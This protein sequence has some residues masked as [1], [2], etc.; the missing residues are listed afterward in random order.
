MTQEK[1]EAIRSSLMALSKYIKRGESE[2]LRGVSDPL[3][4][5]QE[6]CEL[7]G[8]ID[9]F[10]SVDKDFQMPGNLVEFA[11][12]N[13]IDIKPENLVVYAAKNRLLI[14]EKNPLVFA[15]DKGVRIEGKNPFVWASQKTYKGNKKLKIEN[16]DPILWA[17]EKGVD[18]D[19]ED[20]FIFAAKNKILFQAWDVKY[21]PIIYAYK[22][23]L[24]INAKEPFVA[25]AEAGLT[26]GNMDYIER[27]IEKGIDMDGKTPMRFA[28]SLFP[29]NEKVLEKYEL[30]YQIKYNLKD[31]KRYISEKELQG[32]YIKDP[33]A[34]AVDAKINIFGKDPIVWAIENKRKIDGKDPIVWALEN[35]KGINAKPPHPEYPSS[36]DPLIYAIAQKIKIENMDPFHWVVHKKKKITG[37]DPIVWA[38][39][40]KVYIEYQGD[41]IYPA[42][43]AALNNVKIEGKHPVEYALENKVT[44]GR[45]KKQEKWEEQYKEL[46][47]HPMVWALEHRR[48]NFYKNSR[49]RKYHQREYKKYHGKE[50]KGY[51]D[52]YTIEG[53]NPVIWAAKNKKNIWIWSGPKKDKKVDVDPIIWAHEY[54]RG[55]GYVEYAVKNGI[56]IAYEG[57][58]R[59]A[60]NYAIA[61]GV[62]IDSLDPVEY[63]V[64]NHM[65]LYDP[66][67]QKEV[68]AIDYAKARNIKVS[69]PDINTDSPPKKSAKRVLDEA[70]EIVNKMRFSRS[71]KPKKSQVKRRKG[72]A[73]LSI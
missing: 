48:G 56:D 36:V 67:E 65:T 10:S 62:K 61:K 53:D 32:T 28:E 60:I 68:S 73:T 4:R 69:V 45:Y 19:G 20:A 63:A 54:Y 38:L 41:L 6:Y 70:K 25:A 3:E 27:A 9:I 35:K 18:I 15:H 33:I 50:D 5:Y 29:G 8:G 43:W 47:E 58:K 44:I 23:K 17:A 16:K 72:K 52:P 55:K 22:N 24:K 21:N 31:S 66:K 7:H 40:N 14:D 64:K 42:S 37:Q 49:D 11:G 34:R 12:K 71:S 57:E 1:K 46:Y 26:I 30:L 39:K 2:T 51:W 59:P 13:K